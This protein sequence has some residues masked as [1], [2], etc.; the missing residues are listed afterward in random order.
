MVKM[1][2]EMC[3]ASD[4]V[5]EEGLF[6]CQ[7]CGV[8]YTHE[9]AKRMIIEGTVKVDRTEEK[10]TSLANARRAMKMEDWASADKFYGM[11]LERDAENYEAIFYH[12][13]AKVKLALVTP[14]LF[15]RKAAFKVLHNAIKILVEIFTAEKEKEYREVLTQIGKDI[16]AMANSDF[17]YNSTI[18][19]NGIKAVTEDDR[20]ATIRLYNELGMAYAVALETMATKI[21]DA[22]KQNRK[23]YYELAAE[24]CQFVL[25][26]GCQIGYWTIR[27]EKERYQNLILQLEDPETFNK[28]QAALEM[29]KQEKQAK[30]AKRGK[31]FGIL[32]LILTIL[33]IVSFAIPNVR[34]VAPA[35]LPWPGLAFSVVSMILGKRSVKALRIIQIVFNGVVFVSWYVYLLIYC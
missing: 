22:Q 11:V 25:E 4:F 19:W 26:N 23:Q 15:Q 1:V 7:Y 9:E 31:T 24:Q 21:P 16:M 5:K 17:V 30:R 8:K 18:V 10:E 28:H 6:V 34:L 13:Y 33:G 35:I 2:C 27:K 14:E 12:A 3:N 32:S 20:N 29:E